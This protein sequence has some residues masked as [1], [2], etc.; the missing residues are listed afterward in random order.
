MCKS[1][2]S[3]VCNA[4][5]HKLQDKNEMIK[6]LIAQMD[7]DKA[8]LKRTSDILQEPKPITKGPGARDIPEVMRTKSEAVRT[9]SLVKIDNGVDENDVAIGKEVKEILSQH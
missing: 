7:S 4:V 5:E 1:P 9:K 6:N 2:C 3:R 8:E